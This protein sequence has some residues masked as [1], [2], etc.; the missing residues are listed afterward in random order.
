MRRLLLAAGAVSVLTSFAFANDDGVL[1]IA[2]NIRHISINPVTGE[3]TIDGTTGRA[4]SIVWDNSNTPPFYGPAYLFEREDWGDISAASGAAVSQYTFAYCSDAWVPDPSNGNV[5]VTTEFYIN[6]NGSNWPMPPSTATFILTTTGLPANSDPNLPV[7][8]GACWIVTWDLNVLHSFDPNIPAL[9]PIGAS[10]GNTD[11]DGDGLLDF[12][13]GYFVPAAGPTYQGAAAVSG[14]L[15]AY[16]GPDPVGAPGWTSDYNRYNPPGKWQVGNAGFIGVFNNGAGA[17]MQLFGCPDGDSDGDGTCDSTD[18]CPTI[19]N[20]D[21]AD[22]DGD[23]VGDACDQCPVDFGVPPC[24]CPTCGSTCPAPNNN[25]GCSDT[26]NNGKIELN[27]LAAVLSVFGSS[28]SNLPGD[29][30]SPCGSVDLS[31]LAL[32]LSYFGRTDCPI[33]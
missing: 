25:C 2:K 10:S 17:W 28:G 33:P 14:P 7:G 6:E 19:A 26:D 1:P 23:G 22:G 11:Q 29:C 13:Y 5:S 21:Q 9:M 8:F 31:D 15:F 16:P 27:D 3:R 20:P 4:P 32:T 24:G 12:G 30:A 18:N